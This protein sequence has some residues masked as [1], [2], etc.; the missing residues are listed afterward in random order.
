MTEPRG[1]LQSA[2]LI[3]TS[4]ASVGALNTAISQALNGASVSVAQ[5]AFTQSSELQIERMAQDP[6]SMLGLNGRLMS[7]PEAHRFSLKSNNKGNC[8][9][10]YQ[11]TGFEYRL[12]DVKCR[13]I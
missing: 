7:R 3:E 11:R 2:L 10:V 8:Y 5:D 1:S 6:A 4:A 13:V 12:D 9:L